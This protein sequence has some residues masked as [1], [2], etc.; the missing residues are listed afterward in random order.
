MVLLFRLQNLSKLNYFVKIILMDKTYK[1]HKLW[2]NTELMFCDN[3]KAYGKILFIGSTWRQCFTAAIFVSESQLS[4]WS[5]QPQLPK[6]I[7]DTLPECSRLRY[8]QDMLCCNNSRQKNPE[9][10]LYSI[11]KR[12]DRWDKLLASF[13]RHHWQLTYGQKRLFSSYYWIY[14][15]KKKRPE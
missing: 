12:L 7:N 3:P 6:K 13:R 2:M 4:L 11:P 14:H 8:A 1:F 10:Q 5:Q 15:A 9:Q